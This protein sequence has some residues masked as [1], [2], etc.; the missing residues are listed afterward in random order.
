MSGGNQDETLRH[1]FQQLQEQ[2]QRRLQLAQQQ[3]SAK[4]LKQTFDDGSDKQTSS[5]NVVDDMDLTVR[6]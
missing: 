3:R 6:E 4:M 1:Q 2:Q 5:F